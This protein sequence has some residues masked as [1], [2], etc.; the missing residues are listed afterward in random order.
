MLEQALFDPVSE[1]EKCPW[2]LGLCNG[3]FVPMS[4]DAFCLYAFENIQLY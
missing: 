1:A 2:I 3:G 4:F